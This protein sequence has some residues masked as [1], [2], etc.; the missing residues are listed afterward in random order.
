MST[1][2]ELKGLKIKYL[3]GDTSGDRL[4]EGEIF[5]NS[6]SFQLKAPIA[7][8]NFSSGGHL[9]T[10]RY[11]LAGGGTQTAGLAF[12]GD[13]LP[14][15]SA[16]T[17]EYNGL[18]WSGGGN[19]NTARRSLF[20]CGT[21]TAALAAGGNPGPSTT[22]NS[23]EYDGSSWTEGNNLG[24]ARRNMAAAGSQTAAVAVGGQ[25]PPGEVANVE[26]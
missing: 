3:D 13:V 14:G 1:Y 9:G 19:L 25:N 23:E 26:E 15:P 18:N 22:A 5:Y 21:Q 16:L 24:T 10:A 12:G 4:I 17:E 6:T 8:A 7:I 20:G 11:T 2:Q